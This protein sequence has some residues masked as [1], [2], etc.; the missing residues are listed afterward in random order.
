MWTNKS[1]ITSTSQNKSKIP[2]MFWRTRILT[3]NNNQ[4]LAGASE[5]KILIAQEEITKWSFKMK[6]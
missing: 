3:P 4:I 6:S 2:T 1:K 5:D